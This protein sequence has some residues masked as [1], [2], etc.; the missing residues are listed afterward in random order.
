MMSERREMHRQEDDDDDV[1]MVSNL[2]IESMVKQVDEI[3]WE[4]KM[5]EQQQQA[6]PI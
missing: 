1:L 2:L 4:M 3:E 5:N 6:K